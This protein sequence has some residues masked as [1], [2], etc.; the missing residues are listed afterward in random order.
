[1]IQYLPAAIMFF[2]TVAVSALFFVPIKRWSP[3]KGVVRFYWR[4][5]WLFLVAITSVSGGF[6]TLLLLDYPA[7]TGMQLAVNVL[8]PGFVA[9]VVIGWIHM[10]G[11]SLL[12]LGR[13]AIAR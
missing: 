11:L 8:V 10:V 1:M 6:N 13:K 5:V 12:G 2:A 9:F 4:G 7:V 3:E